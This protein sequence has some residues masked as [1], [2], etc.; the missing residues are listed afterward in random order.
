M[1][2]QQAVDALICSWS[3]MWP[4]P[5]LLISVAAELADV[6]DKGWWPTWSVITIDDIQIFQ[7]LLESYMPPSPSSGACF[8][9]L[10][11]KLKDPKAMEDDEDDGNN[12]ETAEERR[13]RTSGEAVEDS[14]RMEGWKAKGRVGKEGEKEQNNV[15]S[16]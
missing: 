2:L 4:V 7:H 9:G 11:R 10:T 15:N 3:L 12:E 13:E 5:P 1:R 16:S 6:N 14:R 8:M